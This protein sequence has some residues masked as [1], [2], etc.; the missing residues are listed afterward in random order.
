MS[1]RDASLCS[2][3]PAAVL[4]RRRCSRSC[5]SA[6]CL[7][8][9]AISLR[10]SGACKLPLILSVHGWARRATASRSIVPSVQMAIDAIS[11]RA[12]CVSAL[13]SNTCTRSIGRSRQ[14]LPSGALIW[15]APPTHHSSSDDVV[16]AVVVPLGG[17]LDGSLAGRRVAV[18]GREDR[19]NAA[20]EADVDPCVPCCPI[21]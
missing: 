14:S 2:F 4:A 7:S 10:A 8:S 12:G 21:A 6:S 18:G 11:R 9:Y 16:R 20:S 19:G 5:I 3:S 17:L 13:I 15:L 1:H